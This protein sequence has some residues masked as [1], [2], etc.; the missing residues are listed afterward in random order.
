MQPVTHLPVDGQSRNV[1]IVGLFHASLLVKQEAQGSQGHAFAVAIP[2]LAAHLQCH[3]RSGLRR[4][5][6]ADDP[7]RSTQADE[8]ARSISRSEREE[9]QCLR[10]LDVLAVRSAQNEEALAGS[11]H[12][13][14]RLPIAA[15]HGPPARGHQV[16][17]LGG[18]AARALDS[19]VLVEGENRLVGAV[20]GIPPSMRD[21]GP[22]LRFR[23]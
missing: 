8:D 21:L 17:D 14:G 1:A 13:S 15:T 22:F 4:L 7:F 18:K 19:T 20:P 16:L 3:L 5:D 23:R 12:G 2:G 10:E 9:Q 11:Q 6:V